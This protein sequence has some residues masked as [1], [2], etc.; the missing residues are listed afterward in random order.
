MVIGGAGARVSS[1]RAKQHHRW[2]MQFGIFDQDEEGPCMLD[3]LSH[4]ETHSVA[5]FAREVLPMVDECVA[6][7]AG[8]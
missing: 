4:E 3:H 6:Q 7:A 2:L 8:S 5:L 1:G